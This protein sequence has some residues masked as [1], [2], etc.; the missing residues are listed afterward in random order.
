MVNR[1]RKACIWSSVLIFLLGFSILGFVIS[2]LVVNA[3]E[4]VNEDGNLW[5]L[6]IMIMLF[7]ASTMLCGY[8]CCGI[9]IFCQ[10]YPIGIADEDGEGTQILEDE[11][12]SNE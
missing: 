6:L 7:G 11:E 12:K 10:S 1:N 4:N 2:I 9:T 5:F 3:L 8:I